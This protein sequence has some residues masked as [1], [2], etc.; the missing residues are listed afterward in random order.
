MAISTI[1]A[2]GCLRSR[3]PST[4]ILNPGDGSIRTVSGAKRHKKRKPSRNEKKMTSTCRTNSLASVLNK[5]KDN[6]YESENARTI[7]GCA[8]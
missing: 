3:N 8:K 5:V 2:L 4:K 7:G 1:K 6:S